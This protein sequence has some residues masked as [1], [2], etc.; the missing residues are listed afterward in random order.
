MPGDKFGFKSVAP[1]RIVGKSL[2]SFDDLQKCYKNVE[3]SPMLVVSFKILQIFGK[4]CFYL[5][6]DKQVFILIVPA[7]ATSTSCFYSAMLA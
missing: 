2:E 4:L 1:L 3:T 5:L 6:V 7:T